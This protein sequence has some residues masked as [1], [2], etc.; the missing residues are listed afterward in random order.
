M[1]R[2]AK[3]VLAAA[4]LWGSGDAFAQYANVPEDQVFRTDQEHYGHLQY[5]GFYTSAMGHWNFTL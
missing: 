5:F 1:T 4:M 2:L 3:V